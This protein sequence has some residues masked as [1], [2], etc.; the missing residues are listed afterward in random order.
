MV[1]GGI[2]YAYI[3]HIGE[4]SAKPISSAIFGFSCRLPRRGIF[5]SPSQVVQKTH[6]RWTSII[7]SPVSDHSG[8]LGVTPALAGRWHQKLQPA[9][10][11]LSTPILPPCASTI[12]LQ[13]ASP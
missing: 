2:K 1:G 8:G 11:L 12:A 10:G 3:R 7:E 5:D 4:K 13:I 9:S 6:S